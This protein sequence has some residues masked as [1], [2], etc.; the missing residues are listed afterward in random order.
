MGSSP[1]V[2]PV[3][4]RETQRSA[5]APRP[6]LTPLSNQLAEAGGSY[7]EAPPLSHPTVQSPRSRGRKR[8]PPGLESRVPPLPHLAS[9][10]ERRAGRK[11]SRRDDVKAAGGRRGRV[12]CGPCFVC[13]CWDPGRRWGA[14]GGDRGGGGGSGGPGH[15]AEG[16]PRGK[17]N[18]G[19]LEL[20]S[21][22]GEKQEGRWK[23]GG[24][25]IGE[26]GWAWDQPPCPDHIADSSCRPAQAS[27][28]SWWKI[29]VR[30]SLIGQTQCARP[31]AGSSD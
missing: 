21:D 13:V 16:P 29:S 15:G 24:R 23:T 31:I 30:A 2:F 9:Q 27:S 7:I 14:P 3:Y 17:M 26:P 4:S 25:H 1:E 10:S 5:F 19:W 11:W 28:P 18:K 8:S 22:P 12:T 20:E 6:F